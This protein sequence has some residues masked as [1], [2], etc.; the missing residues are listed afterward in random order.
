MC[1]QV[2]NFATIVSNFLISVEFVPTLVSLSFFFF[3]F[4]DPAPPE[5]SPL[6]LHDALPIFPATSPLQLH[7]VERARAVQ[8]EVEAA[9][10]WFDEEVVAREVDRPEHG[11]VERH[12]FGLL[13]ERAA[14]RLRSEEHTSELQSQSNL[15][16]RLLLE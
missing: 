8:L 13:V 10:V 1:Y 3:F 6:S 16:C 2:P 14:L 9:D 7:Q 4:N 11:L 15:V 5:I 12:L